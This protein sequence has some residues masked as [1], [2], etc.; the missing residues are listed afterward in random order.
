M[1]KKEIKVGMIV[2]VMDGVNFGNHSNT[3]TKVL[4]RPGA[5]SDKLFEHIGKRYPDLS[6]L[7]NRVLCEDMR[8]FIGLVPIKFKNKPATHESIVDLRPATEE[9]KA[10]YRNQ[11]QKS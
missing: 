1:T 11:K 8:E 9:E 2:T 6:T 3:V 4:S 10:I 7:K 5:V